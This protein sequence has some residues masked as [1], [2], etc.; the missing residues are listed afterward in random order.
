MDVFS[1]TNGSIESSKR[2]KMLT[3]IALLDILLRNRKNTDVISSIRRFKFF[4]FD[5]KKK[6]WDDGFGKPMI[7]AIAESWS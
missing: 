4:L 1:R 6:K 5:S 2:K 3:G 7:H